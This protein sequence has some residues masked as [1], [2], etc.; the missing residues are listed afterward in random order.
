MTAPQKEQQ[1]TRLELSAERRRR[2]VHYLG[3][4]I[5]AVAL[6]WSVI[7][8][9]YHA[10]FVAG[11]TIGGEATVI[12]FAHWQ[13]EGQTVQALNKICREY[14]QVQRDKGNEAVVQQI[15]VPERGYEQ[16]VKTQLIGRTAPDLIELRT[17]S[18]QNLIN[19]YF[20]PLT[21][22]I[23]APN[24]YNKGTRLEGMDWRDTFRDG[25]MGGWIQPLQSFYGVPLTMY[26]IR[27]YANRDLLEQA[28]GSARPPKT[29]GEFL[30]T[31]DKIEAYAKENDLR[32]V[33]IAGSDYIANMFRNR[34]WK[35][36]TWGLMDVLDKNYDGTASDIER[37]EAAYKGP[38]DISENPYIRVGHR[39]LF[40]ITRYFNRGF[41]SAKRDQAVFLFAQQ[42]AVMIA[43]GSWEAGTME[44]QI[45][46]EFDIMVFDFPVAAPDDPVYGDYIRYR[47][48]E[49]DAKAGFNLGLTKLSG[50]K[51][52]AI[53]FMHYLTSLEVNERLNRMWRW[54]PAVHYAETKDF[55]KP[56]EPQD[57]GVY[58]SMKMHFRGDTEL[59]YEN[60]YSRFI[61]S[62]KPED[63]TKAEFF[64]RQ[65]TQFIEGYEETFLRAALDDFKRL[66]KDQWASMFNNEG[67]LAQ[68]R[69][70]ALR[71]GV[72]DPENLDADARRNLRSILFGHSGRLRGRRST[73]R[74]YKNVTERKNVA[75]G[76]D[77]TEGPGE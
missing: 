18:W 47:V 24:P 31:C 25:M 8:V 7:H 16:W 61:G 15:E 27:I 22:Y 6:G 46:D 40:D 63:E 44:V 71:R 76:G 1:R 53:E 3:L 51:K 41:M 38:I 69:S 17:W 49:A 70:K 12:R 56:F 43:T 67:P 36:A 48:T 50:N 52:A 58:E 19:R 11:Q 2:T 77:A 66:Y 54:F 35:M 32:L 26:T 60:G 21:K 37:L 55:L 42:N 68:A 28:A 72:R 30:A 10:F 59:A 23:D 39:V 9:T 45:G 75:T 29:I 64:R 5:L 62:A 73:W 13:L 57:E 65:Y 34:Y 14:E 33:P 20:E 4:A 74:R